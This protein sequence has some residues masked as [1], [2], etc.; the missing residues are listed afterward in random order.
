MARRARAGHIDWLTH[1]GERAALPHGVRNEEFARHVTTELLGNTEIDDIRALTSSE[2]RISSW[3]AWFRHASDAELFRFFAYRPQDAICVLGPALYEHKRW[4]TLAEIYEACYLLAT[5]S[6]G[7]AAAGQGMPYAWRLGAAHLARTRWVLLSVP[8]ISAG[9]PLDR[10]LCL[11]EDEP[12]RLV[13]LAQQAR[14]DWLGVLGAIDD[15]PQLAARIGD[16]EADAVGIAAIEIT[17]AALDLKCTDEPADPGDPTDAVGRQATE[18]AVTRLLLPRFAWLAATRVYLRFARRLSLAFSAAAGL[19]VIAAVAQL[20]LGFVLS[21]T[22]EYTAAAVTAIGAYALIAFAIAA[23]PSAAW[24]WLLR[25]PASAAVGLLAL[26][27]F[28]P[29]WWYT[30]GAHGDTARAVGVILGLA[31]ASLLYLY[32]EAAGHGIRGAKLAWRPLLVTLSGLIHGLL[33]SIIGLRFLLPVFAA[34]PQNGPALSCW[35]ASGSCHG[36]ALPVPALLGLAATWSLAA[37]VFLQII[38]D[39]QPVT[40]PLAHVSWRRGG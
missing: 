33:V 39:D 27:A 13:A 20:V 25:Q 31:A 36:H 17:S 12:G 24:P 1:A 34:S 26:A 15:Y 29:E 23:E 28:G 10:D 4:S 22:G 6:A 37:G 30:G 16:I 14:D 11:V 3:E 19:A 7:E 2:A 18:F 32:I 5:Q 9:R 8:F 21:L 40:S 38:W 35:Y